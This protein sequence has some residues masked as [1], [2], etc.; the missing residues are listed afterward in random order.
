MNDSIVELIGKWI[1]KRVCLSIV[2]LI[3]VVIV[4]AAGWHT[5]P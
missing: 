2:I 5:C 4:V 3:T 1:I